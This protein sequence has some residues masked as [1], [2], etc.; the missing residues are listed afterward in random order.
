MYIICHV[1]V[2][3][4]KELGVYIGCRTLC[5]LQICAKSSIE[6]PWRGVLPKLYLIRFRHGILKLAVHDNLA[7]WQWNIRTFN[8]K[9]GDTPSA[10]SSRS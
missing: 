5:W 1:N 8:K 4:K 7:I 2:C 9:A 10:I 6:L 3:T